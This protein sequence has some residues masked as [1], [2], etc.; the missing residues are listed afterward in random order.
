MQTL[1]WMRMIGDTVF[2]V[3]AIAFVYFA[4][5][6]MLRHRGARVGVPH[7]CRCRDSLRMVDQ[8]EPQLIFLVQRTFDQLSHPIEASIPIVQGR[9][10]LPSID[11]L[12]L[13]GCTQRLFDRGNEL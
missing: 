2:A 4:L 11:D 8:T 12:V 3:G 7:G 13:T 6:L 10:C 9:D 5:D 1:R